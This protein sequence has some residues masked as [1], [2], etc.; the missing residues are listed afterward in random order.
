MTGDP[1]DDL[2]A[3]WR[4][5]PTEHQPMTLAEIHQRARTMRRK[6]RRRNLTEYA[7]GVLVILGFAPVLLH[8]RSWMMQ[9]GAAL[10]IVATVMVLRH[11]HR[12]ASAR[13]VPE[14]G[15]PIVD[16]HREEL[17][18]QRDVLR[19]V[20]RWYLAPFIPGLA[21]ITAGR[22]FQAHARGRTVETDHLIIL[23]TS[24]IV[25]LFFVFV[26]ALNQWGA[27]QLQKRIDALDGR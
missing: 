25:A 11:L 8:P 17:I 14:D 24:A 15:A 18:R 16:F 2:Q 12:M 13:A 1:S 20:G 22:W 23:V 5:Q 4:A 27:K 21:L 10:I 26:W 7:A 6:V 19:T 3:L 9:A